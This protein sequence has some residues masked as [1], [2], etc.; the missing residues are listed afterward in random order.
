[1][2]DFW[3]LPP[4]EFISRPWVS[5]PMVLSALI[6]SI[7]RE[8]TMSRRVSD[9][10]GKSTQS[11]HAGERNNP[12]SDSITTPIHQTSTYWFKN[13][14]EVIEYQ[15]GRKQRDEYG[16]YGNPTWRWNIRSFYITNP[17][18]NDLPSRTIPLPS[19]TK[20]ASSV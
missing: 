10:A 4:S 15:E 3:R 19:A 11:V 18:Y 9:S 6:E 8:N 12:Q 20:S 13:S 16:R 7:E 5:Q 1:M 2:G 17:E 14:S